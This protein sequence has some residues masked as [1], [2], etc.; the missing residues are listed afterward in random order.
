MN[1]HKIQSKIA[2][3]AGGSPA[4]EIEAHA[5]ECA[6][7]HQ[8]L[9]ETLCQEKWLRERFAEVSAHL[10]AHAPPFSGLTFR[11]PLD[12]PVLRASL[13]PLAWAALLAAAVIGWWTWTNLPTGTSK[14]SFAERP[15]SHERA[16]RPRANGVNPRASSDPIA[17]LSEL[18]S[19]GPMPGSSWL[20]E[21]GPMPAWPEE[22]AVS[23][24]SPEPAVS[25]PSPEIAASE[26]SPP[27]NSPLGTGVFKMEPT[28]FAPD[29]NGYLAAI[30]P[31][32]AADQAPAM[33][34]LSLSGLPTEADFYIRTRDAGGNQIW[35]GSGRTD[36]RGSAVVVM[37]RGSP[38]AAAGPRTFPV[39]NTSPPVTLSFDAATGEDL[40][41]VDA[42]GNELLTVTPASQ[43][44]N[45]NP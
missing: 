23:Q 6:A 22:R 36:I 5:R 29:A 2:Q 44:P 9:S 7:C 8:I 25:E 1:C 17:P 28:A 24:P 41:V 39:A 16:E 4:A 12:G 45:G 30:I 32:D 20:A 13:L 34:A 38:I 33:V 18:K 35:L 42:A 21:T 19:V 37:L 27:S 40:V 14:S 11:E 31:N 3:M 15:V 10:L 43:P 26:S